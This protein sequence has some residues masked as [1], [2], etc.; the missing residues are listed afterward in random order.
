MRAPIA[1]EYNLWSTT[2]HVS[3]IVNLQGQSWDHRALATTTSSNVYSSVFTNLALEVPP[4]STVRFAISH[5]NGVRI[6]GT[7]PMPAV[8]SFSANGIHLRIGGYQIAGQPVGYAGPIPFAASN[9]RFFT[10]NLYFSFPPV[11]ITPTVD[12]ALTTKSFICGVNDSAT[13][14][15]TGIVPAQNYAFQWFSSLDSIN[16]TP[17]ANGTQATFKVR[18][19]ANT[20]YRLEVTC[21]TLSAWSTPVWVAGPLTTPVSHYTVNKL[22]TTG[23]T[24]FNSFRDLRDFLSCLAPINNPI[25]VE[26][27]PYSGPYYENASFSAVAG[28]S[29]TNRIFINGNDNLLSFTNATSSN[30]SAVSLNGASFFTIENLKVNVDGQSHGWALTLIYGANH[31]TFRNCTF[32]SPVHSLSQNFA[33]LVVTGSQSS[34]IGTGISGNNNTFENNNIIGGWVGVSI[35][36][37]GSF[38]STYQEQ[39]KFINN[40]I[41]DFAAFGCVIRNQKDATITGNYF[42]QAT[43][44]TYTSTV[45]VFD[46]GTNNSGTRISK[47]EILAIGNGWNVQ[48][49]RFFNIS[50]SPNDSLNPVKIENNLVYNIYANA[51]Q[52]AI[53]FFQGISNNIKIFHN[54]F[55]IGHSN[56]QNSLDNSILSQSSNAT[57]NSIEVRNNI[58]QFNGG[59]LY[60]DIQGSNPDFKT[61]TN[62][63][64]KAIDSTGFHANFGGVSFSDFAQ[65]QTFGANNWDANSFIGNPEFI[66]LANGNLR[67]FS[68]IANDN[69]DSLGLEYDINGTQRSLSQP[70]RGAIEYFTFEHDMELVSIFAFNEICLSENDTLVFNMKKTI[71]H[72]I[73]FFTDTLVLHWNVTGPISSAGT[74]VIGSGSLSLGNNLSVVAGGVDMSMAGTYFVTAWLDTA[75]A[76]ALPQNDTISAVWV[77][78]EANLIVSPKQLFFS[79]TNVLDSATASSRFFS[80]HPTIHF[81]E[82]YQG[83]LVSTLG[84]VNGWPAYMQHTNSYVEIM[85]IPGYDLSGWRL[86]QWFS[87]GGSD[88]MYEFTFK[89]NTLFGPNG[90][91]V[92]VVNASPSSVESPSDFYYHA[93]DGVTFNFSVT[94]PIGRVL[95]APDGTIVDAVSFRNYQFPSA[96]GIHHEHWRFGLSSAPTS[97]FRGMRLIGPDI[98]STTNWEYISA[99]N[100][101]DPN[102]LNSGVLVPTQPNYDFHWS[103]DGVFYDTATTIQ[104]GPFASDGRYVFTASMISPCGLIKDSVIVNVGQLEARVQFIND[105]SDAF[106][107]SVAIWINDTKVVPQLNY[108]SASDF[109]AVEAET[110]V[111]VSMTLVN[112]TDT[113]GALFQKELIFTNTRSHVAIANGVFSTTGYSSAT[114]VDWFVY[115]QAREQSQKQGETDVLLF[116]GA[117]DVPSFFNVFD[118]T[119]ASQIG[120]VDFHGFDGYAM[121]MTR[122]YEWVLKTIGGTDFAG[123]HAPLLA[124]DL[125]DEAVTMLISGFADVGANNNGPEFGVWLARPNGGNLIPLNRVF[126]I[127]IENANH[128]PSFHLFPNPAKDILHL[129][130]ITPPLGDATISLISSLGV[131]YYSTLHDFHQQSHVVLD[132][133]DIPTGQYFLQLTHE[134]G[135]E[136]KKVQIIR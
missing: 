8:N 125:Q 111:L 62:V 93:F 114:L 113:S 53:H 2:S 29:D 57:V 131:T 72:T 135:I 136:V 17:I 49:I 42:S 11:C 54:T 33:G 79:N 18:P 82:I 40:T 98:N 16:W 30:R 43:R 76:N 44:G 89:P 63:Y 81:S 15:A 122:D 102:Q 4:N 14:S 75:F 65:W 112:A 36:G 45:H 70:D 47:N 35:A 73:D 129:K 31:N 84:P 69:G 115:N 22:Q 50:S 28:A 13:L 97:N 117:S 132:V 41:S 80:S 46:I 1:G 61:N 94:T 26:V 83:P 90:T 99:S 95:K 59:G 60:Y 7:N 121:M 27:V 92:A 37:G 67:P 5:V 87:V 55:V 119:N 39:N 48:Q 91:L 10:G 116:H 123:Y 100:R 25:Y 12:E 38:L 64:F 34:N 109:I 78:R 130:V 105:V 32:T 85:G 51:P 96:S 9:P 24:N 107:S 101:Q 3:G 88:Q 77:E 108:R 127:S 6:T 23:G 56:T 104:I 126:G 120:S 66:D 86:E 68:A 118:L 103:L 20:F 21:G 124:L 106:V 52:K 110:P 71:G 19:N 58:F 133:R 134:D 74:V 128:R